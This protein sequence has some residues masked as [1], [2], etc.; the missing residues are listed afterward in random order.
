MFAAERQQRIRELMLKHKRLDVMTLSGLL[1]VTEVTVRRDLEKLEAEG[2]LTRMHGGAILNEQADT[3]RFPEA[4]RV[5]LEKKLIGEIAAM[6]IEN[7]QSVFLGPGETCVQVAANLRD[8]TRLTLL[9]NDLAVASR[10]NGNSGIS[11][12]V[13]GGNLLH[14][15]NSLV[16]PLAVAALRGIFVDKAV[17]GVN[18]VSLEHGLTV[19]SL[20]QAVFLREIL[21]ISKEV[22]MVADYTK[23]DYVGFSPVCELTRVHKVV[24]NKEVPEVYK[25]FFFTHQIK[26]YTTYEP[27]QLA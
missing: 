13:V 2:F 26:V 10:L 20:E 11:V 4:D 7:G 17:I 1:A 19:N 21:K 14:G 25:E 6:L 5:P 8:L 24:T 9:T 3:G 15:T 12:V 18:G 16:G 27:E 22:V 23:F